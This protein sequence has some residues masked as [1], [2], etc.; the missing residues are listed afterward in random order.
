MEIDEAMKL[1]RD[2]TTD[3]SVT[4]YDDYAI[5]SAANEGYLNIVEVLLARGVDANIR[6]SR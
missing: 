6:G 4:N 2:E 3:L 5:H 1:A